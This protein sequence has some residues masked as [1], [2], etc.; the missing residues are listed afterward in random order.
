MSFKKELLR[1]CEAF[2]SYLFYALVI[3]RSMI[4]MHWSFFLQLIVA[5]VLSLILWQ[6]VK[7]MTGILSSSHAANAV[8][9]FIVINGYYKSVGFAVFT[10]ILFGVLLYAHSQLRQHK[11]GELVAGVLAGLI[12]GGAAYLWIPY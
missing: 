2:G 7:L 6:V 12:S 3:V 10:F 4:G 5:L 9:L 8:I 11:K 1:D